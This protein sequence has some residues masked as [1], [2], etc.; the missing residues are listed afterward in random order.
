MT[1]LEKAKEASLLFKELSFK[2]AVDNLHERIIKSYLSFIYDSDDI[3]K[4]SLAMALVDFIANSSFV[5]DNPIDVKLKSDDLGNDF[6]WASIHA[7]MLKVAKLPIPEAKEHSRELIEKTISILHHYGDFDE[8]LDYVVV[9]Y[10]LKDKGLSPAK[11]VKVSDLPKTISKHINAEH[12]NLQYAGKII[13][14]KLANENLHDF[15]FL[16]DS[17]LGKFRK[18]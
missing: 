11:I 13:Y 10:I 14:T 15:V 4:E 9:N 2:E 8:L 5:Y 16:V 18:P 7:G 17:E 6:C 1:K 3:E 12:T